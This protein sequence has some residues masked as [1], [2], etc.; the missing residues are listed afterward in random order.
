MKRFLLL[1]AAVLLPG[2]ASAQD[3]REGRS[4]LAGDHHAHSEFSMRF[5][6]D[7]ADPDALPTPQADGD[8]R[9]TMITNAERARSFG[10]EW[11]VAADHGGPG[12]SQIVYDRAY[13][14]LLAARAKVPE[15][16]QFYGMEFD[17]PGGD[18]STLMLPIDA[19]ERAALRDYERRFSTRDAWPADPARNAERQG[20]AALRYFAAQP[21]PPIL[22]ANHPSRSAAAGERYGL[23]APD[24]LRRWN[25]TAPDVAIGM[26]GAPGHQASAIRPDGG[27]N[28]EGRRGGYLGQPTFGGFDAMAARLGGLWD[29]M[30]GEG[31]RWW[32]TASS[33]SHRNWRDGGNDFWPGEYAK[34]YVHARRDPAD[35]MRG[36]RNGRVFVATGDLIHGLDLRVRVVGGSKQATM[37]ETL[38]VA[39]GRA[40]EVTIRLTLPETPNPHGDRP[41]L[42]RVDLIQGGAGGNGDSNPTTRVAHRFAPAQ[43]RRRGNQLTMRWTIPDAREIR[44]LRVR[45]TSTDEAEPLPDPLG[46]N[47]WRDLWFYSNPVFLRP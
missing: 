46:E 43:W 44:Y 20:L 4:W 40:V 26:E 1:A 31:R 30:L 37:G 32:I 25:D 5:R 36:L 3:E 10:L 9:Y 11:L 13:P 29:A 35:I 8:G 38:D 47:P 19:E 42:A 2:I 14:A 21:R 7:P 28:A 39:P 45:G 24:E 17:T 33:D 6:P 16:I 41:Q 15:L 34:T 22:I 18:H 23:Y 12:R 27:A